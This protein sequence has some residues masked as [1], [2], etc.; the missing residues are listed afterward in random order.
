MGECDAGDWALKSI[1]ALVDAFTGLVGRSCQPRLAPSTPPSWERRHTYPPSLPQH[2]TPNVLLAHTHVTHQISATYTHILDHHLPCRPP[3]CTPSRGC[4]GPP[5]SL[6]WA[7]RLVEDALVARPLPCLL[8]AAAALIPPKVNEAGPCP[9]V[10][11]CSR[12]GVNIRFI[13]APVTTRGPILSL[14]LATKQEQQR[15]PP[16]GGVVASCV[17]SWFA[18]VAAAGERRVVRSL[19]CGHLQRR[20]SDRAT[21]RQQSEREARSR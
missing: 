18:L 6:L 2:P 19:P 16:A 1:L 8:P 17:S 10:Y 7:S 13:R 12:M 15:Q 5:S 9:A 20:I 11:A 14:F 21:I 4:A 3:P